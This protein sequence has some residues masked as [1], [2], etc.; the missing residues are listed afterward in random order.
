VSVAVRMPFWLLRLLPKWDYVC[1]RCKRDVPKKSHTCPHCAENYG[2]PMRVPP[3]VLKDPKA[4]EYYVHKHIFPKV[5][6][7]MREYL[8]NYFTVLFSDGFE[9]GDFSA[10]T[11]TTT[12]E[13]SSITVEDT[14]P[15]SGTKDAKC[16][17][18]SG[19]GAAAYVYIDFGSEYTELYARAYV[20]LSTLL[21]NNGSYVQL[22][23]FQRAGDG[24]GIAYASVHKTSGVV[25]FSI[26]GRNAGTYQ[27]DDSAVSPVVDTYYCVEIYTKIASPDG[28]WTLWIDGTQVLNVT[29]LD[30]TQRGNIQ[31]VLCG[32]YST[33]ATTAYFD[34][35][36]VADAYI[37]PEATLKTV[38]DSLGLSDSVL[39]HKP[40]V[41]VADSVGLVDSSKT[42]KTF[43]LT[44]IVGL[45]DA[46]LRDKTLTITDAV[47]AADSVLGN[48][49]PLIVA[50][51]VSLADLV[52]VITGAIIR[53][54]LDVIGA[55]DL[56][57]V[58][59]PVAIADTVS[60]L[61][62]VFRHKPS[63]SVSDVV[64]ALDAVL[65]SKL[66]VVAD[67]VS[68]ADV[69]KVLK[70]LNVSDVIGLVD[71]VSTPSRVLRALDVVGL[72]DGAFVDKVLL[73]NDNVSLVEVVEVGTGAKKTKLFLVIGD[74]ALQ[75]SGD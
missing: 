15:K 69:V 23:G 30:T 6:P 57:L 8:A 31:S 17:T 13:G 41:G 38:T 12:N 21:I 26:R 65:V 45:V 16:I 54:V 25:Y 58:N 22:L 40:A 48:K 11:K 1:P 56:V 34:D 55:A 19:T 72:A 32:L 2:L 46:V 49:S 60:V 75:I 71:A 73:V 44:D 66:L 10:W 50:D 35:V 33:E 63:V 29:G 53:T 70:S 74:L 68:L 59:K 51:V 4:L 28:V 39:R 42:D 14:A 52:E 43:T 67:A 3:R 27:I 20:R 47:G 37:G 7:E 64:G 9:S 24:S 18:T 61:D 36:V 5:S 62:A